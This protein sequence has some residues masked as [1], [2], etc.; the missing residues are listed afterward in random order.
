MN[1]AIILIFIFAT[2]ALVYLYLQQRDLNKYI[3]KTNKELQDLLECLE[4]EKKN[5]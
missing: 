2:I 1:E 4:G 3:A 5:G